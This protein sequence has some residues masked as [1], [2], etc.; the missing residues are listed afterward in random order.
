MYEIPNSP[1]NPVAAVKFYF[2]LSKLHAECDALF[3][4]PLSLKDFHMSEVCWFKNEPL[5]KNSI[6]NLTQRIS[7]ISF[8]NLHCTLCSSF[9]DNMPPS[10]G[11]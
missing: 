6:A 10:S 4:I 1:L 5:G 11:S 3:Q 8:S 7:I 9:N 2:M